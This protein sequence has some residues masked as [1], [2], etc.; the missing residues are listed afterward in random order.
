[1]TPFMLRLTLAG[2]AGNLHVESADAKSFV[3]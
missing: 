1:V 3:Q 2:E